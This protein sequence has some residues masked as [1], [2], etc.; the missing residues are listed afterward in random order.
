MSSV[1]CGRIV[2]CVTA[3][4]HDSSFLTNRFGDNVK[5]LHF[6]GQLKPWVINFDPVSKK[7][8]APQ[9]YKHLADYL[10]LWWNIFCGEVHPKLVS[11]MVSC[12]NRFVFPHSIS[13][14][15]VKPSLLL[16]VLIN[17]QKLNFAILSIFSFPQIP[18]LNFFYPNYPSKKRNTK[19][20][21]N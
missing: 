21:S 8:N 1:M 10:D 9:E 2:Y 11:D 6:I 12:I 13:N 7:V 5:I 3:K 15:D 14:R 17:I 4:S 16:S 18:A 19:I 20:K